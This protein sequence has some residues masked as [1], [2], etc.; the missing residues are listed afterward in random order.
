MR[1]D[2]ASKLSIVAAAALPLWPVAALAFAAVE[3]GATGFAIAI[4]GRFSG[5]IRFPEGR[6]L[7][8]WSDVDPMGFVAPTAPG[9]TLLHARL[10]HPRL[11]SLL[12]A[13]AKVGALPARHL[14][15]CCVYLPRKTLTLAG[16]PEVVAAI[17]VPYTVAGTLYPDFTL[18]LELVAGVAGG[19]QFRYDLQG[20]G[21]PEGLAAAAGIEAAAEVS[22]SPLDSTPHLVIEIKWPLLPEGAGG[23]LAGAG[24]GTGP[25]GLAR[26][27][28]LRLRSEFRPEGEQDFPPRPGND[29][30]LTIT[31]SEAV[32]LAAEVPPAGGDPFRRA[33]AN[34][35]DKVGLS[36]AV[37]TLGWLFLGGPPPA[38]PDAADANDDGQIGL[39]DTI[40]TLGW[41]FLGGPAPPAPGPEACGQDATP[42]D[43]L[44]HCTYQPPGGC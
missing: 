16:E 20:D 13:V 9:E 31:T 34:A 40:F 25:S 2:G 12:A 10:D 36:D 14:Y 35:A 1:N 30:T 32:A 22:P 33:D 21:A 43:T 15:T 24:G 11:N 18:T 29:V 39:S 26:G 4:D 6:I 27:T 41:L 7:R 37:Y 19:R 28:P 8:E 3:N 38:C 44:G 23:G 5:G 17:R 42:G